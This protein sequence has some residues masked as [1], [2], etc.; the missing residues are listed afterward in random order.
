MNG[1]GT[2]TSQG[3]RRGDVREGGMTIVVSGWRDLGLSLMLGFWGAGEGP[4][5][6]GRGVR[7]SVAVGERRIMFR[8]LR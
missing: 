7:R 6:M 1:P 3:A 4:G 5:A 8:M 2:R